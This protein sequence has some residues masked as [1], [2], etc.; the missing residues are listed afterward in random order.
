VDLRVVPMLGWDRS[1]T[2]EETGLPWVAPSPNLPTLDSAVAYCG[3]GLFEGT[4]VS[5]G[6]GTTRPFEFI[7]APYAD[8]RLPG[9]LRDLALPGVTFRET[10]FVPTFH[11]YA[12]QTVRGVQLHITDRA[13]FDPVGCA[14][15]M[16]GVF[17]ELYPADFSFLPPADSAEASGGVRFIDRLW[18]SDLLRAAVDAG[19]D[20]RGLLPGR[21]TPA[22]LYPEVVLLY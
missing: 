14:V 4:N 20:P 10:W 13:A 1:L 11:K 5:E 9:A 15:S 18:G 16:I 21:S 3:T 12:G 17:A 6:R 7:G 8:G 2:F 19:R 22:Q